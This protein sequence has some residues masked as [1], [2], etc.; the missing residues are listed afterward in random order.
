[1][2][3]DLQCPATVKVLLI[4]L[5]VMVKRRVRKSVILQPSQKSIM[6][7]CCYTKRYIEPITP[8]TSPTYSCLPL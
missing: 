4:I 2:T 8:E 5:R 1:M 3:L 7:V 6:E